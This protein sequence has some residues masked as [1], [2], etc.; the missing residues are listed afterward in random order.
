MLMELI[1]PS[2]LS[3]KGLGD[4]E[5]INKPGH[6]QVDIPLHLRYLPPS[7]GGYADVQFPWPVAFWACPTEE[8]T[9]MSNNPFDRVNLGYDG[10][11]GPRTMFHH[12]TPEGNDNGTLIETIR[13][14]VLDLD[15]ASNV[16]M[17]TIT[18][19]ML[20]VGWVLWCLIRG[21]WRT[22]DY[23][24]QVDNKKRQ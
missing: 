1:P 15:H 23:E 2:A 18:V 11:F 22:R 4:G 21:L 24:N 16:E 13:V 7:A 8:G 17:G 9:L 19:V 6:F 12:L 20:G 3:P 10:L 5:K 14:P